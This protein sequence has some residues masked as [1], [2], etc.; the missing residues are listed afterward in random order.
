MNVVMDNKIYILNSAF[1]T[2]E[3]VFLTIFVFIFVR[4]FPSLCTSGSYN[5]AN[6]LEP[7]FLSRDP[8]PLAST[9]LMLRVL[10]VDV[11][12]GISICSGSTGSVFSSSSFSPTAGAG[13]GGGDVSDFIVVTYVSVR[14]ACVSVSIEGFLIFV[15]FLIFYFSEKMACKSIK[16]L[17]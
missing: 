14:A 13:S 3:R 15:R 9:M 2:G 6:G 11:F 16:K 17:K 8:K 12:I 10:V 5:S 1:H 4:N 7:P